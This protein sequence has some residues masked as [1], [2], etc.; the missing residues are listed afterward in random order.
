[1]K[2]HI[3]VIISILAISILPVSAEGADGMF[4]KANEL[5]KAKRYDESAAL[6]RKILS[7]G[8]VS[9]ELYYN[10]GNA[11]YR[12]GNIAQSIL[13]YE[14]ALRISPADS[15]IKNNLALARSKTSDNINTT[16]KFFLSRW[17]TGIN[18]CFSATCWGVICIVFIVLVCVAVSLFFMSRSYRIR[19]ASF[20]A[21]ILLI[22][23]LAASI[24]NAA[25]SNNRLYSHDEAIVTTPAVSI[26]SSPDDGSAE[27][28]ILHEGTKLFIK[29]IV[30][31]WA[32]IELEDGNT[33]WISDAD[34]ETI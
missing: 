3:F 2:K 22:C 25:I 16:P 15:D 31:N 5:Y 23:L 28:Y 34:Y 10:L 33:G 27:K 12:N 30:G 20:F 29:D 1:M 13:N 19:K 14:R 21:G 11:E 24:A 6:Y 17:L 8:L 18:H 9:A 4:H 32:K 26:K 7:E